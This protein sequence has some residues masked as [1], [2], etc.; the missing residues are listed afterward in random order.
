MN[1]KENWFIDKLFKQI[2]SGPPEHPMCRSN[3]IP[4]KPARIM[5][6]MPD[7]TKALIQE[8]IKECKGLMIWI[9]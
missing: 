2:F 1:E 4:I 8:Y 6:F 7:V 3:I 5:V 9:N